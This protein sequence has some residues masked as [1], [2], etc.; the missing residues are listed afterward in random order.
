VGL[1]WPSDAEDG[2]AGAQHEVVGSGAAHEGLM[3]IVS[4]RISSARPFRT[5]AAPFCIV[6]NS[7]EFPP[8]LSSEARGFIED[9][10]DLVGV[11][12]DDESIEIASSRTDFSRVASLI[13][14][15]GLLPTSSKSR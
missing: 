14:A 4:H 3:E 8:P 6:V 9:G 5:G 10:I 15:V 2:V 11:S 7:M 13:F 1:P 12:G